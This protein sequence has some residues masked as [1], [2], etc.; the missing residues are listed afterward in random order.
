MRISDWSSDV[1]S[2]DLPPDPRLRG[3]GR[4]RQGG[5]REDDRGY[6]SRGLQCREPPGEAG[7]IRSENQDRAHRQGCGDRR[8]TRD[9]AR[10][11]DRK[12]VV[13]GTSVAVRVNL[14]GRRFIKQKKDI[15]QQT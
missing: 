7:D 13:W 12:S 9:L 4:R 8:G 14:G 2:S 3:P 11:R 6:L 10:A 1:C 15:K 5:R